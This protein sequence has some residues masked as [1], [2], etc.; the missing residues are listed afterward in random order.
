MK[1]IFLLILIA[2]PLSAL[3]GPSPAAWPAQRLRG[4]NIT[5]TITAQDLEH[6]VNDWKANSVRILVNDLLPEQAPF[7]PGPSKKQKI[8]DCI[9][10]CLKYGLYTVFS[11]SASFEDND[12]FFSD[13]AYK[14]AYV[15]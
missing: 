15:S 1:V 9:D 11:P 5:L 7:D 6:F 2:L 14:E 8:Y 13:K 4:A 10:L 12:K 3:Q